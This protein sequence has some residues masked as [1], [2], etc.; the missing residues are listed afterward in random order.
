MFLKLALLTAA[1]VG[2]W[3]VAGRGHGA[4]SGLAAGVVLAAA[5]VGTAA[6]GY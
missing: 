1:P 6:L 2:A 5:A 4:W 3:L